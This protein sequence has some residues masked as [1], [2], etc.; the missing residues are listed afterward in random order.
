MS[1]EIDTL[2]AG[3]L[4]P[5]SEGGMS[6][7]APLSPNPDSWGNT[8]VDLLREDQHHQSS[9][10]QLFGAQMPIG[11]TNQQVEQVLGQL[12][13]AFMADASS[14]GYPV[15]M[16]NAAITF[17]TANATKAPYQV[18]RQ[19]NFNL[20]GQDDYLGNAFGNMVQGLSG[21]PRAKQMFVTFCLKWL[22]K[23][24]KQLQVGTSSHDQPR[25]APTNS[26][27]TDQLSDAQFNVLVQHNERVKAQTMNRLAAKYGEY[28]Y[29]QVIELAQAHLES[30]PAADR[31]H[32]DTYTGSWPWSHMLSTFEAIDGLYGMAIGSASLP[33]GAGIDREI[34]SIENVM[35]TERKKYMADPQLQARYRTLLDMK[36]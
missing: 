11:T 5:Y 34:K 12:G 10:P 30:L 19:H 33:T 7:L 3:E 28:T 4:T 18:T 26:D 20:H 36:G 21:S 14:L 23:A 17:M 2:S 8:D 22:A 24:S 6:V 13:G 9:G 32:F 31:A 15:H 25:M 1:N 27:P 35:K 16:T 29:R